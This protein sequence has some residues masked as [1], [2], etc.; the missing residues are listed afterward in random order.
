MLFNMKRVITILIILLFLAPM[1]VLGGSIT[2][3]CPIC[4]RTFR[5]DPRHGAYADAWMSNHIAS[6]RSGR[7][8]RSSGGASD[9]Y[10]RAQMY[11]AAAQAGVMIA[12]MMADALIYEAQQEALRRQRY[13]KMRE[14]VRRA[15]AA[16]LE[17]R[18]MR[19]QERRE[20]LRWATEEITASLRELIDKFAGS[21][22]LPVSGIIFLTELGP[23]LEPPDDFDLAFTS[24]EKPASYEIVGV[25]EEYG[26]SAVVDLRGKEDAVIGQLEA[27]GEVKSFEIKEPPLPGAAGEIIEGPEPSG[28]VELAD[29]DAIAEQEKA[30]E[31]VKGWVREKAEERINITL[32][33]TPIV[34]TVKKYYD[35]AKA[36]KEEFDALRDDQLSLRK[37]WLNRG[38]AGTQAIIKGTSIKEEYEVLLQQEE[39]DRWKK[40]L[41]KYKAKGGIR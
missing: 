20:Q 37:R 38:M 26:G 14:E 7:S 5:F 3:R 16:E 24:P 28:P 22:T 12:E 18:R 41:D 1:I 36:I 27:T 19:Q 17:E 39:K 29:P 21:Y 10:A 30:A 40:A 13:E 35:K 4:G 11:Q 31:T 34:S 6:H 25:E 2:R 23:S 33:N 9:A 15:K 32:D 8:S